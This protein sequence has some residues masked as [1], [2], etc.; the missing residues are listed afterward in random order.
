M[1][2]SG[3]MVQIRTNTS[4]CASCAV[5]S[6]TVVVVTASVRS[7][8]SDGGAGAGGANASPAT[9]STSDHTHDRS[10]FMYRSRTL[11]SGCNKADTVISFLLLCN[12]VFISSSNLSLSISV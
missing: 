3:Q 4:K 2:D 10:N 8:A 9:P 6:A 12:K 11:G 1:N 5:N 7:G